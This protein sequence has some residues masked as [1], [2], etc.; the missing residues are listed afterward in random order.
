MNNIL[1]TFIAFTALALFISSCEDSGSATDEADILYLNTIQTQVGY[2]WFYEEANLYEPKLEVIE[3]IKQSFDP[4]HYFFLIYSQPSC[5]CEQKQLAFPHFMKVLI[6]ADIPEANFTIYSMQTEKTKH[7]HED[8]VTI[9]NLP[10][11][12]LLKDTI[13]VMDIQKA[14]RDFIIA[15]PND[16]ITYEELILE[17][18]TE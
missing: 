2:T 14:M 10:E 17:A 11:F 16:S 6:D 4:D 8:I 3:Q 18:I 7:P 9:T 15:H 1:F 12:Y 5:S 13:V